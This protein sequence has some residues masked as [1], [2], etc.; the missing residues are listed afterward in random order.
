VLLEEEEVTP[1]LSEPVGML[2]PGLEE[3]VGG[4]ERVDGIGGG[5]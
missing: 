1:P 5:P 3:V 2:D 4:V